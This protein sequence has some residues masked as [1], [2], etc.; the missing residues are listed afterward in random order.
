MAL[1][2]I[3]SEHNDNADVIVTNGRHTLIYKFDKE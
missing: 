3:Q 1:L 2:S